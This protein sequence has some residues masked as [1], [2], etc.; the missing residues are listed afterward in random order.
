MTRR[1]LCA[2]VVL[3][4]A[5][6]VTPEA[7]AAPLVVQSGS[8]T[9]TGSLGQNMEFSLSGDTFT[10]QGRGND[11]GSVAEACLP[12]VA[13]DTVGFG[14]TFFVDG[15]GTAQL[16]GTDYG[17]I[18]FGLAF[19]LDGETM[20]FP[21]STDPTVTL[22]SP[23]LFGLKPGRR[24]AFIEGFPTHTDWFNGT[25]RLFRAELVG[26][27]TA[28]AVYFRDDLGFYDFQSSTYEFEPV[29]EPATLFLTSTGVGAL[30]FRKRRRGRA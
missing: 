22:T 11:L 10:F 23:F 12:C 6:V 29:P 5:L 16:G 20:P 4:A 19:L 24:P 27:G 9:L 26:A 14:V 1:G 18:V 13:G 7:G 28:S 15:F 25:N 30:A 2:F 17:N 3:A 8:V 21:A